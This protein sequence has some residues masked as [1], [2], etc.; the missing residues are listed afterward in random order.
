MIEHK[1]E[2]K[3]L[4]IDGGGLRG[5]IPATFLAE[6]E[7]LV[8]GSLWKY[9]DLICGTS[10]GGIIA[11][12]MSVEKPITQI[13]ELYETK[14]TKIFPYLPKYCFHKRILRIIKMFFLDGGRYETNYLED[15]L[16]K[17]FK[18]N[19]NFLKMKDAK[20]KLCIPS[21]D[22]TNGK[23]VVYKTPHKVKF[24]IEQALLDDAEKNMWEVARATSAAPTFF[25]TAK[26]KDS[27]LVDG[28][29]WANNPSLIGVIEALRIGY[30]LDE[31]SLLSLGTG[32][33][34]FQ[35]EQSKASKMNLPNWG[36]S[37]LVELSFEVQSQAVH[38]E[39]KCLL[40]EENYLRIQYNFKRN[41]PMDDTSRLGDLKA[42]AQQLYRENYSKIKDKFLKDFAKNND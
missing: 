34:I 29:M 37:G 1:R 5:I 41:I 15:E 40:R 17:E 24:P 8:N 3:I 4:S 42:A 38:N 12:A 6:L 19:G 21:I 7:K 22:I 25:K 18:K 14:A 9:F 28:G 33:A 35:I 2:F 27:Y 32:N 23:V 26:I 20:T 16:K 30:N 10:T 31:I 36:I 11:L 39:V 13:K